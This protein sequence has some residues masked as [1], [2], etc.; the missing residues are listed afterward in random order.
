ML[1]YIDGFEGVFDSYNQGVTNR[2]LSPYSFGTPAN[3]YSCS[4]YWGGYGATISG[5]STMTNI[6]IP[7][8]HITHPNTGCAGSLIFGFRF[9]MNYNNSNIYYMY[10]WDTATYRHY[11]SITSGN[12]GIGYYN[13]PFYNVGLPFSI[14]DNNWHY[15]ESK[16]TPSVANSSQVDTVIKLDNAI[17][18]TRTR[19]TVQYTFINRDLYLQFS[20]TISSEALWSVDDIYIADGR[21]VDNLGNSGAITDFIPNAW[22]CRVQSILPQSDV[23]HQFTPLNMPFNYSNVDEQSPNSTDYVSTTELNQQDVYGFT[24][25][26]G[27]D[28]NGVFGTVYGISINPI[29][30]L[31]MGAS[32]SMIPVV[33]AVECTGLPMT[34]NNIAYKQY[35]Q[36]I[37][38]NPSTSGNWTLAELNNLSAGLK[39][40]MQTWT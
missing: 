23:I 15:F 29:M 13:T 22:R 10:L 31:G 36:M 18:S 7:Y 28:R 27:A 24:A 8:F 38:K 16:I 21:T 37:E 26:S 5:Y 2:L 9:K 1:T 39:F 6:N 11:V 40:N 17:I 4:G 33:S 20:N 12:F 32:G 19:D 3:I 34:V 30:R 35:K 14:F 25:I